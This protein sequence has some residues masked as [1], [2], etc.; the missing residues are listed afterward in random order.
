MILTD[1]QQAA[2]KQFEQ[3]QFL[4]LQGVT[5]SGKT[6]VYLHAVEKTLQ[7]G[8]QSIVL[9]PEIA[10]TPLTIERFSKKFK[11]AV[12]HSKQTLKER[13]VAWSQIIAGEVDVVVGTR[14]AVF[15]PFKNL[16]L[17]VIDEE[18]D[19][20]YKQESHPRYHAREVAFKRAELIG[21]KL[22]LGSATPSM[23]T[24]YLF[25]QK[26]IDPLYRTAH[27]T[28]RIGGYAL[29]AMQ[30]VD[31]RAEL[32]NG[33]RGV[34]S[35]VLRD[36]IEKT[37]AK[38]EQVILF[39]NRRGLAS[40]VL[41]RACG[42]TMECPQCQVAMAYHRG[43]ILRCHYCEYTQDAPI[44]C[45]SCSSPY[46]KRFGSGTEK[47]EEQ[48]S[49]FFPKA[50]VLRL[51]RDSTSKRASHTKILNSF[52]QG[53]ADILL[54]TQMVAKGHDFQKV[55]LVGIISADT[56]LRQTD[57]RAAEFTF[58]MLTQVAG[59]TGRGILGGQVI[60]QTYFPE[61]DAIQLA[62]RHDVLGFYEKELIYR[63]EVFYPPF[64]KL[65]SLVVEAKTE[66]QVL[67]HA[68]AVRP[69]L[70]GK[71]ILGPVPAPLYH[72]RGKYRLQFLIK[73]GVVNLSEM[74]EKLRDVCQLD[75]DPYYLG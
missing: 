14:S 47:V 58:Q 17:I 33:N 36:A 21:A 70:S 41:C 5:S 20:S 74:P 69:F 25:N 45:P 32:K 1:Q 37:L 15:A 11:V 40:F 2:L 67:T 18:F 30:I 28:T 7:Q 31:L 22:I 27:L 4:L 65:Q 35:N 54:G 23:E 42:K 63:K 71:E 59:R 34:I 3:C 19:G 57:F 16:G 72:F 75:V 24:L 43:N 51:D 66:T 60:V 68:Q 56:Y 29:P 39:L 55:T 73:D 64:C 52:A 53:Q 62:A 46:F 50:K 38:G 61:H 10:L 49:F 13:R 9:V 12:Y 8:K 6:E 26:K 44:K 48:L